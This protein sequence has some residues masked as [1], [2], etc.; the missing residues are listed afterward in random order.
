LKEATKP[1][2]KKRHSLQ[3]ANK[4][5]MKLPTVEQN[6]L[7]REMRDAKT[8]YNMNMWRSMLHYFKDGGLFLGTLS[9]IWFL[10]AQGSRQAS[11]IS[12]RLWTSDGR[13]LYTDDV[14]STPESA[15]LFYSGIYFLCLVL[16]WSLM[17]MRGMTFCKWTMNAGNFYFRT[18]TLRTFNAPLA[19]FFN[20]PVGDLLNVFTQDQLV[21]DEA[22]PEAVHYLAIY[23]LIL[24]FTI[25]TVS[26][27]I[28]EF[29][30]FG[31]ALFAV[32]A[33]ML[34]LYLPAAT[35]LKKMVSSNSGAL[36]GLVSETLE[37]LTVIQAF[38]K[39]EYFIQECVNR[40]DK[41]HASVF[42]AE[43]LNLWLAFF[44]DF[45]GAVLVLG[46]AM[47]A[48]FM[49]DVYDA[50]TAG[51]AFS[52]T[53]QMLVFYTWVVRFLAETISYWGSVEAAV[54]LAK[55]TPVE[56]PDNLNDGEGGEAGTSSALITVTAGG[57][58]LTV[59]VNNDG[60]MK[61]KERSMKNSLKA[62]KAA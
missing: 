25:F 54:G 33:I 52:N 21:I 38:H 49:R 11:D 32:S 56:D 22:M 57:K 2:E 26:A 47:F 5:A 10:S 39:Q 31:F 17:F 13:N 35:Q 19:F 15:S 27:I 6:V 51:L 46:V 41:Y 53:I 28:T 61:V 44:C 55:Y 7:A 58:E 42:N 37:G 4:N 30:A 48:V 14:E 45:F 50:S 9:I 59:M 43:S 8:G 23:G 12:I 40:S 62:R 1:N 29:F 34:Y 16:F 18:Y 36:V 20:N 60:G 24:T 3:L